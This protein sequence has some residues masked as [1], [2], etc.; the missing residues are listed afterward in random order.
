MSNGPVFNGGRRVDGATPGFRR[1][2][3]YGLGALA[4][5]AA[6]AALVVLRMNSAPAGSGD[7]LLAISPGASAQSV[8]RDLE[9][10][11]HIRSTAWF[12][13]LTR[14]HRAESRLQAGVYQLRS[15]QTASRILSDLT[16]GRTRKIPV[17]V[18]EGFA[19]W[20]IAER[21]QAA[22]ILSAA[23]FRRAV[24]TS[25][26]EGYLFPETYYLDPGMPAA[27]VVEVMRREFD[28]AWREVA[29]EA[30]ASGAAG[31]VRSTGT[32][33]RY[34]LADGRLWTRN[35][36]VT[37]ASLIEREA[38]RPEERALISAV[39]HN[40]LKKGMRL[41]SDPTVQFALGYWKERIFYR[42]LDVDS[43]YNTYRRYGL[44]P[45][46][47]CSPGRAA[48]AAALA[49]E[50]V[51]Y[52]YFVANE[53]GGHE[54]F[55]TYRQHLDGVRRRNENRRKSRLAR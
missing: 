15:G 35:D 36:L 39:F 2:L 48:L 25:A 53:T 13:F 5:V 52:L 12:L 19:S 22:G 31:V 10:S 11:G 34:R 6:A 51:N 26:A 16:S 33:D 4:A 3:A 47:I 14:W 8:A 40:R 44:P 50:A 28:K 27:R 23:E 21:L 55:E 46:P 24:S 29:D 38:R 20:Q 9:K 37:L 17:T 43:P 18:P 30:L 49:P 45:G 54:F 42:D 41:E 32:E 1:I 7:H